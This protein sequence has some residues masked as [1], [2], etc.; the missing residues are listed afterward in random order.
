MNSDI[1]NNKQNKPLS[2]PSFW[3]AFLFVLKIT[4]IGFGGGNA[5]MPIIEKEAI[6][7]NNWASKKEFEKVIIVTN[8]IPG[9]SVIQ[10]ISFL[11]IKWFGPLK[12]SIL[13][14]ISVL[15]HLFFAL[16]LFVFSRYIPKKY[17][18]IFAL[19][20]ICVVIA[21]LINFTISFLKTSHKTLKL[22]LW[23]FLFIFSSLFSLFV[24]AP[25]NVSILNIS[26]VIS[27][28]LLYQLI[29]YLK[30]KKALNKNKGGKK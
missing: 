4:F 22:P 27:G 29:V 1:D 5:L 13:T 3:Q 18:Y 24:P 15:P 12:G 9:A 19:A 30:Q 11:C 17:L 20:I 26:I 7:K 21:I 28:T 6:I 25:I 2:K 16:L 14:L 8:M 10:A 23:I